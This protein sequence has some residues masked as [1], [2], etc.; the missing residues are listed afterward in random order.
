MKS[1][2]CNEKESNKL[3]DGKNKKKQVCIRM[4]ESIVKEMERV[5]DET[6]VPLSQQVEL[7]LKG[8]KICKENEE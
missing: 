4:D 1:I 7:K 3:S 2:K 6:G 8:Y 5:R